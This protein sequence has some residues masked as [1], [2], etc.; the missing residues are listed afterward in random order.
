MEEEYKEFNL[1]VN[2]RAVVLID[3]DTEEE[4]IQQWN[5][6]SI[7]HQYDLEYLN[8]KPKFTG[9]IWEHDG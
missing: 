7:S 1:V 6:C 8:E 5:D 9:E 2:H 3:A 4:A